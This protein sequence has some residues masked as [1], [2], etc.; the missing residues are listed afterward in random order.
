MKYGKY[1]LLG[2]KGTKAVLDYYY[3]KGFYI[4]YTID[5]VY[6]FPREK[7]LLVFTQNEKLA[8]G[9]DTMHGFMIL[10]IIGNDG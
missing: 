6:Y 7:V 2:I 4:N 1:D 10:R 9:M 3:P 8:A 5:K